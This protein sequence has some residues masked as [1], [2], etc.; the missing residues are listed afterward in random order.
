MKKILLIGSTGYLGKK[1][2]LKLSKNNIL[3]CP[4]RKKGFDIRKKSELKKYLNNKID[5]VINLSGQQSENQRNMTDVIR[6]GNKNIIELSSRIKKNIKLIYIST[7]LVYGTSNK[8]F[9]ENSKIKPINKYEKN[10][11]N[12]KIIY[13][14]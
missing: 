10:K 6:M 11:Y 12:R 5:I 13:E 2:K 14:M 8:I 4:S 1:L 3:V 7:S 9:K